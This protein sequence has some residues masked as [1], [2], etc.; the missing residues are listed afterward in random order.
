MKKL[1]D[2]KTDY[3]ILAFIVGVGLMLAYC[4][5]A[6]ADFSLE[7]QH[8]SNAGATDYNS[9]YDRVCGR[10]LY[11]NDSTSM[12]VCP[13][14]GVR[15]EMEKGAFELGLGEKFGRWEG[16][17]R[18]SYVKQQTWGGG[19]VR[20]VIGDGPFQLA[21]GLTYWVTESPGTNS[22]LTYNLMLRYTW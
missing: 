19:S 13:L 12:Y 8:D 17:I 4:E 6:S 14:A 21:L 15:G 3:M 7:L 1:F 18:L 5:S 20:R 16:D 11:D 10:W 9:G 22:Q 2:N